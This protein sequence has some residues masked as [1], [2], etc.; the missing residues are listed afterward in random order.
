MIFKRMKLLGTGLLCFLLCFLTLAMP[1]LAAGSILLDKDVMLTI[2][3][4]DGKTPLTG[5]RFELYRV[6]DVDAY[7]YSKFTLTGQFSASGVSVNN[8]DSSGWRNAAN[9][10]AGYAYANNIAPLDSGNT[11][12]N[13]MLIFPTSASVDMRAGLYLV[14]GDAHRQGDIDYVMEPM[15]VSLPMLNEAKN[16]WDYQGTISP[17][18]E[19][20]RVPD[21]PQ[22]TERKVTKVWNDAGFE[23]KRPAEISVSLLCDGKVY[24]TVTLNRENQWSFRW[25]DLETGHTW[26]IVESSVPQGYVAAVEQR[27]LA[28]VITNTYTPKVET[29]DRTV[30]KI[31]ND[32]GNAEARPSE[33]HI[34]L[35]RDGE[36]YDTVIL[37]KDNEWK[38]HWNGLA[39]NHVWAVREKSV[40]DGYTAVVTEDGSLFIVTN[41]KSSDSDTVSRQVFKLWRD[42]GHE[43]QRPESI[44]VELLRNGE[45]YDTV[46]LSDANN[47]KY[48]W[49]NLPKDSEWTVREAAVPVQ[50]TVSTV[51]EGT[52]YILTNTYIIEPEPIDVEVLKIWKDEGHEN[53]RPNKITAALLRDGVVYETVALHA[54]NGWSYQWHA[55]DPSY[56]WTVKEQTV[57]DKYTS[58]AVR[59]GDVFII[60]NTYS[61]IPQTG[62][63]WWPVPI[64]LAFGLGMIVIG[65]IR[66][67]GLHNEE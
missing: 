64:L 37:T 49:N 32:D 48:S 33:V 31:W 1:I 46:K 40:P 65:L 59:D 39:S 44:T 57:L 7:A 29:V 45:V 61:A 2:Q 60:T 51:Q 10:L 63:L 14:I 41:T 16:S 66:R 42:E 58:S 56:T 15:L 24:D 17:K 22:T 67:R 8:L 25:D 19:K 4:M 36:V 23:H 27:G 5:A 43:A 26:W 21:E 28:F 12:E 18:Y 38:Y 54:E 47:W 3:Y 62:Q 11:D 52:A 50:Y 20:E 9:S 13:G 53:E 34:E 30:I 55:L 6:A 35:L